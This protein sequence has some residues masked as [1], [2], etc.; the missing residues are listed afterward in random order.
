MAH[1]NVREFTDDNFKTEAIE[2]DQ[3]VLVDFWADWCQ[4]C[5]II[6]PTIDELAEDYAGR[7][8]VGKVD[9]DANRGIAV[10]LGISSIPTVILFKDGQI[11]RKFVG[12][13]AKKDFVAELDK[14]VA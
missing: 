3:P 6:A 4:P 10:E 12:V 5:H 14:A 11:V 1:E 2:A 13:T 9:T 8:K 7:V